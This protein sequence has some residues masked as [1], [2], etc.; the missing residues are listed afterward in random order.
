MITGFIL[1]GI[2]ISYALSEAAP[3]ASDLSSWAIALL[4]FIGANIVLGIIVQIIF[5]IV[6]AI[7]IAAREKMLEDESAD[8]VIKASLVEDERDKLITLKA[9][10]FGNYGAGI[11]FIISLGF[12]ALG[13]P[14]VVALHMMAGAFL[15]G[16]VIEGVASIYLNERG[17][18]NG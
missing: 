7:G 3:A 13:V 5:H 11:G 4:I 6:L 9:S 18:R 15:L 17:V 1:T 2:Y 10:Q 8:R 16:S 12:L 14:V